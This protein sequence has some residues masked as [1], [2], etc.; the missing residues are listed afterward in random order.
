LGTHPGTAAIVGDQLTLTEDGT[1]NQ[2]SVTRA[3]PGAGIVGTGADLTDGALP[4]AVFVLFEDLRWVY[5]EASGEPENGVEAGT[6]V[7]DGATGALT[8][9]RTFASG[10]TGGVGPSLA[11]TAA[12][13]GDTLTLSEQ[14]VPILVLARQ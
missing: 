1:G 10:T 3:P 7:Y 5:V 2:L 13:A 9:T 6:Y 14:G 12:V 8:F 4:G 11:L